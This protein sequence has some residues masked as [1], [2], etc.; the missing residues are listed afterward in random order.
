MSRWPSATG[1]SRSPGPTTPGTS[2]PLD[3]RGWHKENLVNLGIARL[4]RDSRY[5]AWVDA[6]LTFARHDWVQETIQ[7]LQHYPIVQMFAEAHDLG[8]DGILINS[9]R[10]FA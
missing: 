1:R 8:P 4:P 6:D 10:S 9:F 2:S 7:Q 5:V 3:A